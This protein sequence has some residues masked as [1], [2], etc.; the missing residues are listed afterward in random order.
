M[1]ICFPHVT[2]PGFFCCPLSL[3]YTHTMHVCCLV[4]FKHFDIH[5][6]YPNSQRCPQGE[7]NL[8][9]ERLRKGDLG[10]ACKE[11]N[12]NGCRDAWLCFSADA[13]I[14]NTLL[15]DVTRGSIWNPAWFCCSDDLVSEDMWDCDGLFFK[16]FQNAGSAIWSFADQEH[17]AHDQVYS[18]GEPENRKPPWGWSAKIDSMLTCRLMG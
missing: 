16:H 3:T 15:R 13:M 4:M 2:Y 10:F 1:C 17:F 18:F 9:C 7:W 8:T 5:S 12:K 14:G 11:L 6:I